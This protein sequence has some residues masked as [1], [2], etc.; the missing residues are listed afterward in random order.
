MAH[1]VQGDTMAAATVRHG[2]CTCT[3]RGK[4]LLC[5]CEMIPKRP[6]QTLAGKSSLVAGIKQGPSAAVPFSLVS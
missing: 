6:F 4:V 1:L 3:L 5:K 2:T